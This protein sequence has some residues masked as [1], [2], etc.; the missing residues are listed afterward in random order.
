MIW[1]LQFY[2]FSHQGK[3]KHWPCE[4]SNQEN[5]GEASFKPVNQTERNFKS[6]NGYHEEILETLHSV[7]ANLEKTTRQ[8]SSE[9]K[10]SFNE[11]FI[12]YEGI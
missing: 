8:V 4:T 11:P 3:E 2:P 1:V 5:Q 9:T 6:L 12:N 7:S 10:K